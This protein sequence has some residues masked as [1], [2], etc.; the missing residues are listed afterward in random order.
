MAY[1][2]D[3]YPELSDCEWLNRHYVERGLSTREVGDLIGCTPS[4]VGYA[5]ARHGIPRRGRH[6]GRW[7]PKNCERCGKQYIPGGPAAQFCSPECRTGQRKCAACEQLFTPNRLAT[8]QG[9]PSTEKYCS[10]T[11]RSWAVSQQR[12]EMHDRR[13]QSRPPTRRIHHQTG[14][15][16]IY[17]GARGGGHRVF[18]HRQVMAEHLGRELLPT[19]TVHH[20]NGDK[21]DN[22]IGNLQLRQGRHGRGARF[23]C[24]SCGSHDVVAAELG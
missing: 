21:T 19:E 1:P 2:K 6:Y 18:E 17:Y 24:N 8:G 4:A 3:R 13:R 10:E 7:N 5:L 20:I 12:M 23:V 15:V 9:V 14:Y 22:R 16:E 11:C